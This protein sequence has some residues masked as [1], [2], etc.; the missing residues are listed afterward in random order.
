MQ[1]WHYQEKTLDKTVHILYILLYT[2][3]AQSATQENQS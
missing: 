1:T 3:Y 2:V